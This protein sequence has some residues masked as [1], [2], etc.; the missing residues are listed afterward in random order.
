MPAQLLEELMIC[1]DFKKSGGG[2]GRP[3]RDTKCIDC[4]IKWEIHG[5]AKRHISS[6]PKKR[7]KKNINMTQIKIISEISSISTE[8]NKPATISPIVETHE[9][10]MEIKE[11][12]TINAVPFKFGSKLDPLFE[13]AGELF[14]QFS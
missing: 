5:T 6:I 10:Q 1:R 14:N 7:I 9:P 3:G 2:K 4:G 13:I 11:N 8:T 12:L